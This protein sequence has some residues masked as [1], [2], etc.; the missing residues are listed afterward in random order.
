LESMVIP[1]ETKYSLLAA[2]N[3]KMLVV[4]KI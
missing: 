3:F 1:E 4:S 2:D